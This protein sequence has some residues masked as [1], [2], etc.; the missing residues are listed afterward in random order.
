MA[1]ALKTRVGIV[2]AGPAGLMLS[3]LLR[4]ARI[5][6][7]ILERRSRAHC[8]GRMR[9]GLLEQWASEMLLDTGVGSRMQTDGMIHNGIHLAVG[10]SPFHINFQRLVDKHVVVYDQKEIVSDLISR[11]L[12][13]GQPIYFDAED[14]S[15]HDFMSEQP[16]IHFRHAGEAAQID[17]DFIVGCDGFH[18]V[19]RSAVPTE[20]LTQYDRSYPFAWVGV[21]SDSPPPEAELIYCFHER[22]FALFSMRGATLSRHY[23]QCAP[24]DTLS[25]WPDKRIWDELHKRLAG[26]RELNEGNI[27]QKTI[28]PMRSFVVDPMQFGRLFLAGDSAHI[29]PPTG[30]KGMNLALADV[31]VLSRAFEAHFNSR[32][33]ELLQKYSETALRRVWQ[34][35]RFSFWMTTILHRSSES[36]RFDLKRQSAELEYIA[37]SVAASESLAE[38]YTGLRLG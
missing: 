23:V 15:I 5:P 38:N 27:L 8:E 32:N 37:G 17:C 22:G 7:I 13:D 28:V 20:S 30:A 25:A 10:G 2:G 21:L 26:A 3:H 14:V 34:A 12:H 36:S 11:S 19:C 9:A 1:K 35:Q 24:D 33:D 29:L 4:L 31:K 18:G 16:S 6:S